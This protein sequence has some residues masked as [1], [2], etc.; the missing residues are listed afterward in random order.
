MVLRKERRLLDRRGHGKYFVY[1][2]ISC[3]VQFAASPCSFDPAIVGFDHA[4]LFAGNLEYTQ[5]LN[6]TRF[7]FEGQGESDEKVEKRYGRDKEAHRLDGSA[8]IS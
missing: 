5:H 3:R 2:H 6:G 4:H 1:M 7:I 8:G